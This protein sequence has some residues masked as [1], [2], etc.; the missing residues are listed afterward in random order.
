VAFASLELAVA[1]DPALAALVGRPPE[2]ELVA[3]AATAP[4]CVVS[5]TVAGAFS[6]VEAGADAVPVVA[7]APAELRLAARSAFTVP[8]AGLSSTGVD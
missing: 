4:V 3:A 8:G 2:V 1:G 7:A 5:G 6:L